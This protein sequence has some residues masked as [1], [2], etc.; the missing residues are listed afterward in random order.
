[1]GRRQKQAERWEPTV[2]ST[3]LVGAGK[4]VFCGFERKG[5]GRRERKLLGPFF[6]VGKCAVGQEKILSLFRPGA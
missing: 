1:M 4:E 3:N 6:L 5:K 2:P